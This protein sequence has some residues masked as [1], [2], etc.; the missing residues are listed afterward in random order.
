MPVWSQL[1]FLLLVI[2]PMVI[3][4]GEVLGRPGVWIGAFA[5]LT[6]LVFVKDALESINEE[7]ASDP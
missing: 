5:G 6:I 4:G 3:V 7:D 1:L 2:V